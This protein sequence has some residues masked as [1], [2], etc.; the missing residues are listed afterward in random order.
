MH[1]FDFKS[2]AGQLIVSCQPVPDGAMDQ[3]PIVAAMACAALAGGATALRIQSADHVR[4]VRQTCKAPIFGLVKRDL[5]DSPVRIT[6][7]LEDV[8]A[9]V[10]AGADVVAIDAT[11]RKRPVSIAALVERIHARGAIAMADCSCLDDAR[12]ALALGVEIIGSTMSGYVGDV[13]P[14]GPDL[15][16]VRAMRALGTGF[17]IAEGRYNTTQQAAQAIESGAHAVVVGTAITRTE[18]VTRW[19]AD[20]VAQAQIRHAESVHPTVLALDIG[21]TKT[22]V[23][24]VQ[25]GNVIEEVTAPTL[26]NATADDWLNQ[27]LHLAAAWKGRYQAVAAGVTGLVVDGHWGPIN[28]ATLNFTSGYPLVDQMQALFK[29]PAVAYNDAQAA[30]WAEHRFGAGR[31]QNTVYLTVSTG[32]GGGIVMNGQLWT[33][34]HALAGHFGVMRIDSATGD[35]SQFLEDTIAGRWMAEQARAHLGPDANAKTVFAAERG[36]QPWA[37][38]LIALSAQR[39]SVLCSNIQKMLAP[40]YIVLGGGI[41]L[42][43]GYLHRVNQFLSSEHPA[44]APRVVRATL[45]VQAGVIGVADLAAQSIHQ[46]KTR[47]TQ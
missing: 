20:A 21:G 35:P 1:L 8:D 18:V 40:D 17:V 10:D 44:L 14:E 16:L 12:A 45:G 32:I 46:S 7:L 22:L 37:S 41:G 6:A 36:Q 24:L 30:A 47:R 4:A 25:N 29:V 2:L 39:V 42:A 27:A 31:Q 11:Q 15:E 26:P 13:V 38:D 28:R 43:E 3:A 34:R 23:A 19:F 5:V 9:L 33:G